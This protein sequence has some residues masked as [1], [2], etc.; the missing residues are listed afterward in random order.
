MNHGFHIDPFNDVRISVSISA[1]SLHSSSESGNELYHF[2]LSNFNVRLVFLYFIV[3]FLIMPR[4]RT[5]D[6]KGHMTE[7][8]LAIAIKKEKTMTRIVA[9]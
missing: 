4:R 7:M 6:V 9:S 1:F 8:E 5:W 2:L 3:V